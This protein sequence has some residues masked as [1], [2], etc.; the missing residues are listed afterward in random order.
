MVSLW[1]IDGRRF[2]VEQDVKFFAEMVERRST[3]LRR[4]TK[5]VL[6]VVVFASAEGA[7]SS[8]VRRHMMFI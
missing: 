3:F 1:E 8:E 2:F 4:V 5:K 7:L 6:L